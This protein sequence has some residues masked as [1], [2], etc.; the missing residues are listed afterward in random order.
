MD[1]IIL[2]VKILKESKKRLSNILEADE[3]NELAFTMFLDVVETI[4][5]MKNKVKLIIITQDKRVN[6]VAVSLGI[7][8]L[9]EKEAKGQSEAVNLGTDKCIEMN[10]RSVLT[11]PADIPLLKTDDLEEIFVNSQNVDVVIVPSRDRNGTNALFRRPPN[12]MKVEFGDDS[13]RKHIKTVKSLKIK[14]VV[15][16]IE[17]LALDIDNVHDLEELL[18]QN[19]CNTHT[20][21]FL[22]KIKI[23]DRIRKQV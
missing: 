4:V 16:D 3:R 9:S 7:Q 10:I 5:K 23:H 17:R 2:P 15:L 18:N 20:N 22:R 21:D 19:E 13:Y 6:E 14:H 8:V 11:L 12:V 1:Y